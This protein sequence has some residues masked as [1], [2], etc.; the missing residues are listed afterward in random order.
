VC[1]PCLVR[2]EE[3]AH[4][5]VRP[6]NDGNNTGIIDINNVKKGRSLVTAL[7]INSIIYKKELRSPE[8]QNHELF[9]KMGTSAD[10]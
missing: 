5:Q 8:P 9:S 6:Y 3:R 7:F 4:T 1:L 10:A 2:Y